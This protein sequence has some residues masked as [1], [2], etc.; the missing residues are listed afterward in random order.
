MILEESN[1]CVPC[2]QPPLHFWREA[3]FLDFV[4]IPEIFHRP[5]EILQPK[6]EILA[7]LS[8]LILLR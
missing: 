6:T 2:V 1:T 4:S 3:D 7:G 8:H 5:N